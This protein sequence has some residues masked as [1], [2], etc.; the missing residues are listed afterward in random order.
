MMP[1]KLS[2]TEKL[3]LAFVALI[4]ATGFILLYT[5]LPVFEW[6]V[7]EDHLV[8]WLTVLGLILGSVVCFKRLFTLFGKRRPWFLLVTFL[9]GL[10]LFFAAGEEISWGQ[11]IFGIQSSEYFK[12]HNAQGETNLHNLVVNGVK[13]NKLIFSLILSVCMGIYLV[14]VP[15]L[16]ARSSAIR[17]FL[18]RSAVPVAQLYQ[19]IAFLALFILTALLRHEKNAEI[20]ECGAA[21]LFFLIIRFPKNRGIFL[22]DNKY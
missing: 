19:V 1:P 3:V 12:E 11:R 2:P 14:V 6:Y 8:E 5:N 15:I 4:I 7:R 9:L 17:K 10:L 16:H 20:L 13:I 18:D 22:P 21:L